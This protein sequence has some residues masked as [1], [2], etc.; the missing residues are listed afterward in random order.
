MQSRTIKAL[1]I[2]K[3]QYETIIQQSEDEFKDLLQKYN[4]SE[5]NLL[6]LQ[7]YIKRLKVA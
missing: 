4:S 2:E 1:K 5:R 6:E 7:K 3:H